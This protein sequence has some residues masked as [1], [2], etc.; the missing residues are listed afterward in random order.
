[1]AEVALAEEQIQA[2]DAAQGEV[3]A[4]L[5]NLGQA[6]LIHEDA[7]RALEHA[8]LQLDARRREARRALNVQGQVVRAVTTIAKLPPG[9]WT[10]DQARGLLSSKEQ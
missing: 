2:L 7:R 8:A 1:M 3:T 4:A 5:A 6:E 10:Y 9:D